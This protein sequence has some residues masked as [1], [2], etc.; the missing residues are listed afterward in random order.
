MKGGIRHIATLGTVYLYSKL[1]KTTTWPGFTNS[2]EIC[3]AC[4]NSPGAKGCH[5]VK[6][7]YVYNEKENKSMEVDHTNEV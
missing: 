6:D 7:R 2:V 5:P 1:K 3:I 4:S